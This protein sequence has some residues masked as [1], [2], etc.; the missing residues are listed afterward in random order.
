MERSSWWASYHVLRPVLRYRQGTGENYTNLR[1]GEDFV[2]DNGTACGKQPNLVAY[3]AGSQL[4][5]SQL[6]PCIIE[7]EI[8]GQRLR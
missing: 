5:A 8:A 2:N 1:I 4:Y 3:Y 7:Q 6:R